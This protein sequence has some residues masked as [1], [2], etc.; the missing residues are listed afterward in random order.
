MK[1]KSGITPPNEADIIKKPGKKPDGKPAS[2]DPA[3]PAGEQAPA[4]EKPSEI[5]DI[6][7]DDVGKL[8][9]EGEGDDPEHF[10]DD[11]DDEGGGEAAAA[12][13]AEARVTAS[14][15]Q[16]APV[17]RRLRGKVAVAASILTAVFFAAILYNVFVKEC[18]W[19]DW[20]GRDI[21]LGLIGLQRRSAYATSMLPLGM[22]KV[23]P[24]FIWQYCG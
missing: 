7:G 20:G 11:A 17:R 19:N 1:D 3:T 24:P 12:A 23:T 5:P 8:I 22:G 21:C 6:F 4:P 10:G 15:A 14:S 9:P 2:A 13:D 18:K 16:S